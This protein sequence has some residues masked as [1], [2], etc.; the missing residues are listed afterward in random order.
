MNDD[1]LRSEGLLLKGQQS[2]VRGDLDAFRRDLDEAVR[3]APNDLDLLQT[4]CHILCSRGDA[5]TAK[6]YLEDLVRR[7]PDDASAHHDLGTVYLQI[8]DFPKAIASLRASPPSLY[9][10]SKA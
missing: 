4:V 9:R 7:A 2:A 3:L 5:V 6:R 1:R 8:R 10:P